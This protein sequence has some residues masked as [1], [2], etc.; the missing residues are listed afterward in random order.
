MIKEQK[1]IVCLI[2][3]KQFSLKLGIKQYHDTNKLVVHLIDCMLN[4]KKAMCE[5][6]EHMK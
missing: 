5:A 3:Y 2:I 4:W 6:K 1:K